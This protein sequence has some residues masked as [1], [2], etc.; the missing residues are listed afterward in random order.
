MTL[1]PTPTV[2]EY[3]DLLRRVADLTDTVRLI[4]AEASAELERIE[5]NGGC[6]GFALRV[7]GMCQEAKV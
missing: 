6:A 1:Q 3:L 7:V 4:E 5:R 2:D